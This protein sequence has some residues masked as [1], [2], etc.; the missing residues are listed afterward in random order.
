VDAAPG[1]DALGGVDAN[2]AADAPTGDAGSPDGGARC[3][4][5]DSDG[6][7]TGPASCGETDCD[8]TDPE[9]N[10]GAVESCNGVDDDCSG[11][12]DDGIVEQVCG[13]GGC[14]VHVPGCTAGHVPTC[15]PGTPSTEICNAI[16]DDCNGTIDD[17]LGAPIVCGVGACERMVP[18]CTGGG[19]M[20]C[21]PGMPSAETCNGIDD[22][23]DGTIDDGLPTNSCGVGACAQTTPSCVDGAPR[24]CVP[25]MPTMESCNGVDD[26]CDGTADDGFGTLTCGTGACSRTVSSCVMGVPQMC[27]PLGGSAET[28]NNLD[29]DCNGTVDD[30][31]GTSTCGLGACSRTVQNCLAG[32]PQTC[33]PGSPSAEACNNADDDC[34]GV[35]DDMG[36]T[37]CGT[38]L[39]AR[40]YANCVS[41]V[42]QTCVPGT[43]TA[44][45]CGNGLDEDCNGTADNGCVAGPANDLCAGAILLS[46]ASGTRTGDSISGATQQ[47]SDCH[48]GTD[49][50]YR[51]TLASRS[52]LYVDTFGSSFD[53]SLSIRSSCT[54]APVSC[55]D[56]DCSTLQDVAVADLPAGTHYIVVHTRASTTGTID[57][58][59]QTL[60]TGS[61]TAT[62]VTANGTF[63]GTTGT[64][65]ATTA[66]ATCF[67]RGAGPEN[68]H[69]FTICPATTR[70]VTMATCSLAS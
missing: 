65:S 4:D 66:S 25:G 55:E 24:A 10:P 64:T 22:D 36:S 47:L 13:V 8:D 70:T 33:S 16:D 43:P 69:Y 39:C 5:D 30:G 48:F 38:G 40:T 41:G 50:F 28:C 62:R 1:L 61:G 60:A 12:I 44:E 3:V 63:A 45:I 2:M 19:S 21:T 54:G 42:M 14:A 49:L 9:V 27:V 32:V 52:I 67:G 23:C 37:S 26:D 29:D 34:N 15:A 59:W 57:L 6:F 46:G 68:L 17:G 35:T 7:A 58:R 31:L 18:G 53:T 56:D 20:T 51:I 11:D